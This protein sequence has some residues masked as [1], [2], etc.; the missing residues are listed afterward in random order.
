MNI[1]TN[2]EECFLALKEELTETQLSVFK[3]INV[4]TSLSSFH[5]T[6]G[7]RLRNQWKLWED[8]QLNTYFRKMGL[9]HAD[10]MSG[11]ILTSF[12]RH[13]RDV[14]LEIETQVK[15]YQEFWKK[16]AQKYI[17]I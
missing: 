5:H 6:L 15:N 13:L 3:E 10:D 4:E 11:L 16:P 17:A 12:S 9:F 8:S 1:P 14:P 2:L 7:R